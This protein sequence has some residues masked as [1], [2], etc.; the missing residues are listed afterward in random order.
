MEMGWGGVGMGMGKGREGGGV[1][2]TLAIHE[3]SP[4]TRQ[5]GVLEVSSGETVMTVPHLH[6]RKRCAG[7][8]FRRNGNDCSPFTRQRGVLEASLATDVCT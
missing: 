6:V 7:G 5:R 3:C 4:F 1:P 2:A 8:I